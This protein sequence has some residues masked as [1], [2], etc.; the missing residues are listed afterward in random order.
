MAIAVNPNEPF[1]YVLEADR[2]LPPDEQTVFHLR[3]LS[4]SQRTKL[5]DL[6]FRMEGK[7]QV[8]GTPAGYMQ[9]QVLKAGLMGWDN[10]RD[11]HGEQ[12]PFVTT[13]PKTPN[14]LGTNLSHPT[15]ECLGRLHPN[16][17]AELEAA[18]R[19]VQRVT[20]EEGKG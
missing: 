17:A 14:V 16:D 13:A 9:D 8:V 7:T 5:D 18:I 11:A 12:V 19:T 2:D 15:D 4:H 6:R 20:D 10:L 1:D 3:P